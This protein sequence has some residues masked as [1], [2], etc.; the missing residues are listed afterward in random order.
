MAM[1]LAV[2]TILY[3]IIEGLVSVYFGYSD[4]S[5]T[6]FGFGVDS[7]IEALSAFGILQ[8]V[9][10][11][12][13]NPGRERGNFEKTAL[14]ITGISFYILMVGLVVSAG[15][16]VYTKHNPETTHWGIIISLVSIFFMWAL[17][18]FKTKVGR[19]LNS[20]AMIA[21]AKCARVCL[22]MSLVL[23]ASSGLYE[24]FKIPYIDAVGSLGLAYFSFIEAK[25]CFEKQRTTV[26]VLAD[27]TNSLS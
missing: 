21:D 23:L 25:E 2:F 6:L 11:I 22:Y 14:Y 12:K 18:Y 1:G 15:Y 10:R 17:I 9:L 7:F 3:N 5:F 19:K 27:A 8:M 13:N 26:A 24:L 16:S 20:D 4:G